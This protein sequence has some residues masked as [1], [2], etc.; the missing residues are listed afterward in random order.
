MFN[1]PYAH[2][3]TNTLK[4]IISD[5]SQLFNKHKIKDYYLHRFCEDTE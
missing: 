5:T 4:S 1:L 2:E 3:K